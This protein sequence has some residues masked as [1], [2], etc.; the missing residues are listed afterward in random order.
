[1]TPDEL[2]RL[3]TSL[4]LSQRDLAR[5]VGVSPRTVARWE[6]GKH[7]IG[8]VYEK[9]IRIQGAAVRMARDREPS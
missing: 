1:M 8:L 2:V 5:R 3:R 6:E 9:L 4:E 7:P